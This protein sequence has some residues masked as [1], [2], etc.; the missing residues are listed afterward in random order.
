MLVMQA[1]FSRDYVYFAMMV[2][3]DCFKLKPCGLERIHHHLRGRENEDFG[4]C[5]RVGHSCRLIGGRPSM[6]C[7]VICSVEREF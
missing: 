1:M 4:C 5:N 7:V 3:M 6:V 2:T